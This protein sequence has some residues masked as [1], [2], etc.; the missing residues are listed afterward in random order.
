[1]EIRAIARG[2]GL[3][4]TLQIQCA[5]AVEASAPP[6]SRIPVEIVGNHIFVKVEVNGSAPLDFVLDTGATD[7]GLDRRTADALGIHTK[8][9]GELGDVGTGDDSTQVS[10]AEEVSFR[11]GG[12]T[13]AHKVAYVVGFGDLDERTGRRRDRGGPIPGLRGRDRL[14]AKPCLAL[15]AEAIPVHGLRRDHS[16]LARRRTAL[17]QG[18]SRRRRQ[19]DH[20]Q[21]I[22]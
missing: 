21:G 8:P 5:A 10:V 20:G 16:D 13:L 7:Y 11:I 2:V 4:L 18:W 19:E 15:Q 22:D 14:C 6:V 9:L 1:M 12:I 3:I 17:R